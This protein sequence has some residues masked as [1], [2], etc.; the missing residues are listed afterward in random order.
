MYNCYT[1]T[2][3]INIII[4]DFKSEFE[5]DLLEDA[6][7]QLKTYNFTKDELHLSLLYLVSLNDPELKA[8]IVELCG[9]TKI[10]WC[11]IIYIY[12]LWAL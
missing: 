6:S 1:I 7:E 8:L 4:K 3:Y 10:G 2:S 12:N 9:I 11:Y 5:S